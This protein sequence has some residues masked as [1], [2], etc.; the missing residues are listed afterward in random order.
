MSITKKIDSKVLA[1]IQQSY[2]GITCPQL[3]QTV[4][5]HRKSV[6][7]VVGLEFTKSINQK[8]YSNPRVKVW[9][10]EIIND[11]WVTYVYSPEEL[12]L[13]K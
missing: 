5:P 3:G 9:C 11:K 1:K 6:G 12:N 7:I 10:G 13:T 4:K 8:E 2:Q